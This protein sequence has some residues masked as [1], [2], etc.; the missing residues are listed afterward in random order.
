LIKDSLEIYQEDCTPYYTNAEVLNG[1]CDKAFRE[2]PAQE[3]TL[4]R[5]MGCTTERHKERMIHMQADLH[6]R[7]QD[8]LERQDDEESEYMRRMSQLDAEY[9][10]R[11]HQIQRTY[12]RDFGIIKG[13]LQLCQEIGDSELCHPREGI[14]VI[15]EEGTEDMTNNR[16][17]EQKLANDEE[18]EIESRYGVIMRLDE[19]VRVYRLG[20]D[21]TQED[22]CNRDRKMDDGSLYGEIGHCSSHI[23]ESLHGIQEWLEGRQTVDTTARSTAYLKKPKMGQGTQ[24]TYVV[25]VKETV[26]TSSEDLYIQ[27]PGIFCGFRTLTGHQGF[28]GIESHYWHPTTWVEFVE[29]KLAIEYAKL[30]DVTPLIDYSELDIHIMLDNRHSIEWNYK[31]PSHIIVCE[32][33]DEEDNYV[34]YWHRYDTMRQHIM[35]EGMSLSKMLEEL[36]IVDAMIDACHREIDEELQFRVNNHRRHLARTCVEHMDVLYSFYKEQDRRCVYH[37]ARDELQRQEVEFPEMEVHDLSVKRAHVISTTDTDVEISEGLI[38][39][40]SKRDSTWGTDNHVERREAYQILIRECA[41]RRVIHY[42]LAMREY[43][44]RR[45]KEM[46]SEVRTRLICAKL[47]DEGDLRAIRQ[48]KECLESR[49]LWQPSR[50]ELL[51]EMEVQSLNTEGQRILGWQQQMH[52]ER[53]AEQDAELRRSHEETA[54]SCQ[55]NIAQHCLT[56]RM[57]TSRTLGKR[58]KRQHEETKQREESGA[59]VQRT[60]LYRAQV[61]AAAQINGLLERTRQT[62][63]KRYEAMQ[64]DMNETRSLQIAILNYMSAEHSPSAEHNQW[65]L[66]ANGEGE[67]RYRPAGETGTDFVWIPALTHQRLKDLQCTLNPFLCRCSDSDCEEGGSDADMNSGREDLDMEDW[68]P[69]DTA[70][71]SSSTAGNGK[72]AGGTS[73]QT[74][75]LEITEGKGVTSDKREL[76]LEGF[77]DDSSKVRVLYGTTRDDLGTQ[78][79]RAYHESRHLPLP[80]H[81]RRQ[82]TSAA[83]ESHV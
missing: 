57:E 14:A 34:V 54:T 70:G 56:G 32:N 2:G 64:D 36:R 35:T 25:V 24:T 61:E 37:D 12:K 19:T 11:T 68:M 22:M 55:R 63:V 79:Q 6:M 40:L 1:V 15:T 51:R 39:S 59:T 72:G 58:L 45:K 60:S 74:E 73:L 52:D 27:R 66:T 13:Y 80:C 21:E 18:D 67:I 17:E 29:L 76:F 4:S 20:P 46:T 75:E 33:T 5:W 9:D 16:S 10:E 48:W 47:I 8:N 28:R 69:D 44:A 7:I 42:T 43:S 71:G 77:T 81:E 30:S 82:D 26:V 50:I 65:P 53:R 78:L 49:A 83:S 62:L 23:A 31:E 38:R 3:I 41:Y